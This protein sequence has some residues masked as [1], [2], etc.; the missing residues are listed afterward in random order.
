MCPPPSPGLF[1]WVSAWTSAGPL[2][3]SEFPWSLSS[4]VLAVSFGSLACERWVVGPVSAPVHTGGGFPHESLCI[5]QHLFSLAL[6]PLMLKSSLEEKSLS[7]CSLSPS[8]AEWQPPGEL[9]CLLFW[10]TSVQLLSQNSLTDGVLLRWF[11]IWQFPCGWPQKF[12]TWGSES[13][14][15]STPLLLVLCMC[16]DSQF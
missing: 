14:P 1:T 12:C 8:N 13:S 10:V 4:S 3:G 16:G 11:S 9:L 15:W 7:S 5:W 2:K 6:S